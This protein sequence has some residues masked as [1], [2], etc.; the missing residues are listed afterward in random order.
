MQA[1]KH[2]QNLFSDYRGS[3]FPTS[4]NLSFAEHIFRDSE[5][6]PS[7]TMHIITQI[8]YA[9]HLKNANYQ[10]VKKQNC[11]LGVV[12]GPGCGK[13]HSL[14]LLDRKLS[15]TNLYPNAKFRTIIRLTFSSCWKRI[16][17]ESH[18]TLEQRIVG[19]VICIDYGCIEWKIFA[20]WFQESA[21]F[22]LSFKD[23]LNHLDPT[24]TYILLVDE[25]M[26]LNDRDTTLDD[27]IGISTY[28]YDV[29]DY[30][31]YGG[32]NI[33]IFLP[34]ITSLHFSYC[35]QA[36]IAT[37][38]SI[39]LFPID[40]IPY[41]NVISVFEPFFDK[42]APKSVQCLVNMCL[43]HARSIE[44]VYRNI[45]KGPRSLSFSSLL[46]LIYQDLAST[47]IFS[48]MNQSV[49]LPVFL[50]MKVYSSPSTNLPSSTSA[51]S[52]AINDTM[53]RWIDG[54]RMVF[55]GIYL[56]S[57]QTIGKVMSFLPRMTIWHLFSACHDVELSSE[58]SSC[59]DN[60]WE[61]S[62]SNL[63]ASFANTTKESYETFTARSMH[64]RLHYIIYMQ[65]EQNRNIVQGSIVSSPLVCVCGNA[66]K[67]QSNKRPFIP[68]K[69]EQ[70]L[71][72]A[73][74][75]DDIR[76]W[77]V[78]PSEQV[79]YAQ[80]PTFPDGFLES[81]HE[82][83]DLYA[84]QDYSFFIRPS[85]SNLHNSTAD[86]GV[87]LWCYCDSLE[88]A[89]GVTMM[90]QN[91]F[92]LKSVVQPQEMRVDLDKLQ[93]KA[94]AYLSSLREIGLNNERIVICVAAYGT[95]GCG[96]INMNVK[97]FGKVVTYNINNHPVVYE[98]LRY[99]VILLGNSAVS[100]LGDNFA[101]FFQR[102][103]DGKD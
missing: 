7:H 54:S 61:V 24:F 48:R 72:N 31:L 44:F 60:N 55:E 53:M 47:R 27:F 87:R 75:S 25:I 57:F 80:A 91:K 5:V 23:L 92:G 40:N 103:F 79:L 6:E 85:S 93:K 36:S 1:T 13:S 10:T 100:L 37:R 32:S 86:F 66:Q 42:F 12:A 46:S 34:F 78:F 45:D 62:L 26:L 82:C 15:E 3:G 51:N 11:Y 14:D 101:P 88:D 84:L 16:D 41:T 71:Y 30:S 52:T 28:L 2:F 35:I 8:E 59:L 89:F 83:V 76:R 64:I 50:D 73:V 18:W 9:E 67:R 98:A 4:D 97:E 43:G 96:M 95:D 19:R 74:V 39:M 99:P 22:Q 33:P 68:I 94:D 81:S 49:L 56:N 65:Q 21:L 58:S 70:M 20:C 102:L 29:S 77:K 90:V 38:R 63:I 69:S 17:T